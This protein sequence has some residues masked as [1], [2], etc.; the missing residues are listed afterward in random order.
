M[1][2]K[3]YPQG[4]R[5]RVGDKV[6]SSAKVIEFP[7]WESSAVRIHCYC[8]WMEEAVIRER[9]WGLRG[10]GIVSLIFFW[11]CAFSQFVVTGGLRDVELKVPVAVPVG[12]T[13][14]LVCT[15]DLEGD[16]LY[17]VKWY[18]GRQEFFRYVPKELPHTRVFAL[19][20]VNVDVSASGAD[21]VV[22]RDVPL[23]LTGKYRCEVSTDAPDF[24][25]IVV[26]AHMVVVKELEGEPVVNLEKTSYSIGDTLRGNCSSPPAR[27]AA[28]VTWY[29]NDNMVNASYLTRSIDESLVVTTAGIQVEVDTFLEGR[30]KVRCVVD[31]YNVYSTQRELWLDENRPRLASVLGT[32]ESSHG[33]ASVRTSVVT[34]CIWLFVVSILFGR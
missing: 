14:T 10:R 4:T 34:P 33:G 20:G 21:K 11:L 32:R 31:V 29:I 7:P 1:K 13:A 26:S 23:E 18:K 12:S 2:R 24:H 5:N 9:R 28:N 15:Y 3:L 6:Q 22:L 19:P 17:T 27:P 25:T 16:P 30:I 8:C